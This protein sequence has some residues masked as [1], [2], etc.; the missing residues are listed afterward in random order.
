MQPGNKVLRLIGL[1][2]SLIG[3]PFVMLGAIALISLSGGPYSEDQLIGGAIFTG[4]GAIFLILGLIFVFADRGQRHFAARMMREGTPYDAEITRAYYNSFVQTNGKSPLVLEC[5]YKDSSG[6]VHLVKSKN[7]WE[8]NLLED[9]TYFTARVW[10]EPYN[11]KKYY[12]EVIDQRPMAPA[13][14]DDR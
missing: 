10:V 7:L 13:D 1:I 8:Y 2:F 6:S 4:M 14:Y 12:V 5:R 3:A 9:P 11:P